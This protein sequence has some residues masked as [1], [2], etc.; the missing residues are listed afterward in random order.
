MNVGTKSEAWRKRA[1]EARTRRQQVLTR[2]DG[3][4]AELVVVLTEASLLYRWGTQADR[5]A[6]VAHLVEMSQ[7]PNVE[8]RLLRFADG[9]HPGMSSLISI[10]D[11]P[12]DEPG[13]VYLENDAAVQALDSVADIEVYARIF[14][15]IRA[16]GLE[17]AATTAYLKQLAETHE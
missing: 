1:R 11:F 13:L 14:A 6:Q 4:S 7:R 15:E 12:G 2:E 8:L 5:R 3:P 17:P 16:A 9:P 10:F